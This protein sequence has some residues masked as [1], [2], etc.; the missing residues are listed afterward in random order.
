MLAGGTTFEE[1]PIEF[2]ATGNAVDQV[3][4]GW[5]GE[6]EKPSVNFEGTEADA[7]AG[8][9][10]TGVDYYTIDGLT[11]TNSN[12]NLEF[13]VLIVNFDDQNGAHNN[14]VKNV[15]ITLDKLNVN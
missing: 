13:G 4:I 11:I 12:S 5:D 9:T 7:E 14:T 8:F 10:L 6:G 15:E 2:A 1:L 3:Y